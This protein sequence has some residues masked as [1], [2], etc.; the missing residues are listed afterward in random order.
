MK[1]PKEFPNVFLKV[2]HISNFLYVITGAVGYI[3]YGPLTKDIILFNLPM[4]NYVFVLIVFLYCV[5]LAMT[6][7]MHLFPLVIIGEMAFEDR[8]PYNEN[9]INNS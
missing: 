1:E 9:N 5:Q 2:T 6:Y 3:L 4:A 8:D 7:S